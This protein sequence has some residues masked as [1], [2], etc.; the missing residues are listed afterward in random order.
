[1]HRG[2]Y[3]LHVQT[4]AIAGSSADASVFETLVV[5]LPELY[6]RVFAFVPSGFDPAQVAVI[7]VDQTQTAHRGIRLNLEKGALSTVNTVPAT[8]VTLT[9]SSPTVGS[10]GWV[11]LEWHLRAAS[12]GFANASID[13]VEATALNGPQNLLPGPALGEIGFGLVGSAKSAAR[14]I[15][16]DDIAVGSGPIG[17]STR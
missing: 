5:P 8:A 7:I 15:W 6:V 11:C 16:L 13:G 10:N 2:N 9:S 3:S 14:E 17:C 4:N 1:V 12:S